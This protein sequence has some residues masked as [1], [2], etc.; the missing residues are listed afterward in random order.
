MT[1]NSSPSVT[2]P[3]SPPVSLPPAPPFS[4]SYNDVQKSWTLV[5]NHFSTLSTQP[6]A[7]F[8][9]FPALNTSDIVY[10]SLTSQDHVE[11]FAFGGHPLDVSSGNSSHTST[12]PFLLDSGCSVH[13]SNTC[14]D[15]TTLT[16]TSGKIVQGIGGSS[17]TAVAISN[18]VLPLQ[19]QHMLTLK[20]VLFIPDTS[21]RLISISQLINDYKYTINFSHDSVHISSSQGPIASGT[22]LANRNLFALDSLSFDHALLG[23]IKPTIDVWHHCLSH[24]NN[25]AIHDMAKN[26]LAQG[27]NINLS[28]LPPKCEHCILGKQKHTPIPL[29]CTGKWSDVRFKLLWVDFA[30]LEAIASSNGYLYFMTIVDDCTGYPWTLLLKH[31]KDVLP[32]LQIFVRKLENKYSIKLSTIHCNGGE[33][34]S[35]ATHAWCDSNGYSILFSAPYS[36]AHIGCVE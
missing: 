24:A 4:F 10:S 8:G 2:P 12:S 22:R 25:Q 15:F 36:S 27:M 33:L 26:G 23:T 31:K 18:I 5:P 13:I 9:D 1:G 19:Y 17:I 28:F 29:V 7:L 21:V 11:Y 20:N 16:P 32:T 35:N 34:D 14:L 6:L 3:F 30:G